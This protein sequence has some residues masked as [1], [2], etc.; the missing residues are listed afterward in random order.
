M[1][2]CR[3]ESVVYLVLELIV[4]AQFKLV[5]RVCHIG[6]QIARTVIGAYIINAVLGGKAHVLRDVL[7]F[8]GDR[9]AVIAHAQELWLVVGIVV[10]SH[11][12][13]HVLLISA[14]ICPRV[15]VNV[16]VL[17]VIGGLEVFGPA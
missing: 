15:P 8:V 6:M 5:L 13:Q 11:A 4:P 7:P 14:H 3:G 17:V 12:L 2:I 10:G 16:D 1:V 9:L